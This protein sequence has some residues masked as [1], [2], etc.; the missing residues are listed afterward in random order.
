[1]IKRLRRRLIATTMLAVVLVFAA[2]MSMVNVVNHY[3]KEQESDGLLAILTESGG[4]FR[5]PETKPAP[6]PTP[7]PSP[8][9]S[10]TPSP[11]P[12]PTETAAVPSGEFPQWPDPRGVV[13]QGNG[14]GKGPDDGVHKGGIPK[15]AWDAYWAA[16]AEPS[17]SPSAEPS[18]T[19]EPTPEPSPEPT[20]RFF[21]QEP[22]AET[23]YETRY[24]S[25]VFG[26]NGKLSSVDT[27]KIAAVSTSQAVKMAKELLAAEETAGYYGN[28]K[29]LADA[30][31]GKT[32]YVFLD[33]T[34]SI[35]GEKQLLLISV[36]VSVVGI[37]VIFL[38]VV[39]LS[40]RMIRP[41]VESYEKQKQFITNAGH[42]IKTPLAVID[43]CADVIELE[44][45]ESKWTTGIRGQVQRL[46]ALTAQLTSLARLDEQG[47]KVPMEEFDLSGQ[48]ED[49][50]STFQLL[51]ESQGLTLETDVAP[52]IVYTGNAPLLEELCSIL[53]DNAVKYAAPGGTIVF[54][55]RKKGRKLLLRCEN[56]A[57]E[58]S[59][60]SQKQLFDR[61]YRGDVSH[62]TEKPGYG[63]GLSMAEAIVE[64]H[65]GKIEAESPDG[66]RF[67]ITATL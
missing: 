54:S 34:K 39:L 28:Y 43:S 6:T 30:T 49:L 40:P 7:E 32:L 35:Q 20:P 15:W 22:T 25:V 38:I 13:G 67:V 1:M 57:E 9:P 47:G 24:F 62:G 64:A 56:P 29:Y 16:Q 27:S 33:C 59:E 12:E 11:S 53:L 65:R 23:P 52:G 18:P 8:S 17:P 14:L 26:E 58:L 21:Y 10:P 45:G 51:A 55:L 36:L 2:I 48:V 31:D 41:V 5:K 66:V 63:I 46:G 4:A 3:G 44:Q 42:E 61:F 50:L 60:G 19:P 37:L